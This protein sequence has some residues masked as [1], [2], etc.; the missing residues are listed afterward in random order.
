[1]A[2]NSVELEF[3]VFLPNILHCYM[4]YLF[5]F[6]FHFHSIVYQIITNVSIIENI[7]L[8]SMMEYNKYLEILLKRDDFVVDNNASNERLQACNISFFP[9]CWIHDPK[10]RSYFN[11]RFMI[12]RNGEIFVYSLIWYFC[13]N[14]CFI[15]RNE[16]KF[17]SLNTFFE[18]IWGFKLI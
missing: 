15:S 12:R 11:Y 13:F 16:K 7:T 3:K 18:I 17:V 5:I 2:N 1:M 8:R 14:F 6:N 10:I 4:I 9:L